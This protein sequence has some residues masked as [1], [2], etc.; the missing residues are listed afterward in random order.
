MNSATHKFTQGGP[1]LGAAFRALS[2]DMRERTLAAGVKAMVQPIKVAAKRFAR[3]SRETGALEASITDK[4]VNYPRNGKCVGLVGPDRAYYSRGKKVKGVL[5][6]AL[7]RNQRRPS[8]YAHLVEFGH[9]AVHP[10]KGTSVRKKTATVS[11]TAFVQ[12][13][14]FLRPAVTTTKAQQEQAFFKGIERGFA[15]AVKREVKSGRHVRG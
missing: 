14:P 9:V 1:E 5:S 6:R 13:K 15:A 11:K 10:R 3:R 2:D 12:P 7:A 4:V 8:Q